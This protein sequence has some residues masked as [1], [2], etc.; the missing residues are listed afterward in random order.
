MTSPKLLDGKG[1]HQNRMYRHCQRSPRSGLGAWTPVQGI[2]GEVVLGI[3]GG[4]RGREARA[5]VLMSKSL[6]G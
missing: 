1:Q 6:H 5:G 4:D 3:S 2:S